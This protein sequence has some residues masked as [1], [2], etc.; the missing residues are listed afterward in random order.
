[1]TSWIDSLDL[2]KIGDDDRYKVL[3]YVVGKVGK[4]KVMEVLGIS[5]ITVWRLL[6]RQ[7][8]VDDGK[9]RALLS[10]MSE[11]EF[12]EVLGTKKALEAVGIVRPDGSVNYSIVAEILRLAAGDEYLK[13]LILRF[14][15][16]NFREDL[17]KMLGISFAGIKL[18]WSDDF[19][20]FLAE[21]K[22]RRKVRDP[23]TLQYYKNLFLRY[24]QGK[25]LS[26][27]LI[28][29]V[30]NHSNK[31][32]RNVFRHYIQYLYHKRKITP[33]TFGWIMEV[34]PSRGYK[35]DVRPYQISVEDIAKTMSF[36]K[37]N[38]E[39]YYLVYRLMLEGGLRLSHTLMLIEGFNPGEEIEIPSTHLFTK[40]LVCLEDRGFCRYYLGVRDSAK[41]CEWIYMSID[42]LRLLEKYKGSKINRRLVL[43]YAKN[44]NLLLPKYIRKIAWRLMVQ[45]MPREVARFIQSRFGELKVSEAR[46]EDLLS[47]ADE[48]YPKYLKHLSTLL[49]QT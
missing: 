21:R 8:R 31:W 25:E 29:Y 7:Q 24:L 16:E 44:H 28:D 40:R 36:L 15:V 42:S 30:V 48:N 26:E 19:E 41:P 33:E 22:K 2:N 18:E 5:K 10:L 14:A 20:R 38:S 39:K 12:R 49:Q 13:Q 4:E 35:L 32:L 46:Y 34:V 11:Q 17:R 45:A 3:E 9:L 37:K 1:M 43:K 6:N 47:E 23:E 27:E